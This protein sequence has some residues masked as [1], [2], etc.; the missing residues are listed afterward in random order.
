MEG[1]G[2]LSSRRAKR[3]A[4]TERFDQEVAS[5][6]RTIPVMLPRE[7]E[8]HVAACGYVGQEKAVRAIALGPTGT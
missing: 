7:I 6:V 8:T 4:R 5:F 2:R 3:G 1:G